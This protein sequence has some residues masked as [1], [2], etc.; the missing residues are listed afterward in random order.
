LVSFQVEVVVLVV[1]GLLVDLLLVVV[2]EVVGL[3]QILVVVVVE[4]D[5]L[6]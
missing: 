4:V 5:L 3:L 6:P 2:V 1:V